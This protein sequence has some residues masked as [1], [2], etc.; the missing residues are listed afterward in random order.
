MWLVLAGYGMDGKAPKVPQTTG[1]SKKNL[2]GGWGVPDVYPATI[3]PQAL[4]RQQ[5]TVLINNAFSL[6]GL[7]TSKM[8][9]FV[10]IQFN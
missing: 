3:G 8:N 10:I 2:E 7:L 9:F 5:I 6:Y 1:K 4:S